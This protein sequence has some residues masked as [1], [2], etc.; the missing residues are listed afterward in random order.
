M[1]KVIERKKKHFIKVHF[2]L[3]WI[4]GNDAEQ[5]INLITLLFMTLTPY[6]FTKSNRMNAFELKLNVGESKSNR[7]MQRESSFLVIFTENFIQLACAVT[8]GN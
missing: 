7:R 3:K 4:D 2:I 6:T 1:K 5:C 8:I